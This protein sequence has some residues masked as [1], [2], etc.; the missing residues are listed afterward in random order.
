MS[1]RSCPWAPPGLVAV[2]PLTVQCHAFQC[3]S[4]HPD[5]VFAF[6]LTEPSPS[7]QLTSFVFA[8]KD[9][10]DSTYAKVMLANVLSVGPP[11]S[12]RVTDVP[13]LN[14]EVRKL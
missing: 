14:W 12:I 7:P 3:G 2:A 13:T 1:F 9:S 6:V 8:S 5:S 10:L 4:G 11:G